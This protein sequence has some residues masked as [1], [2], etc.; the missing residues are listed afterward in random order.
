MSLQ[1]KF[2]PREWN[3]IAMAQRGMDVKDIARESGIRS[4]HVAAT[5]GRIYRKLGIQTRIKQLG[6]WQFAFQENPPPP[7]VIEKP[8]T[9]V[10]RNTAKA[11]NSKELIVKLRHRDGDG[12]FFC[13]NPIDFSLAGKWRENGPTMHIMKGGFPK[14][15]VPDEKRK[16]A[17]RACNPMV[18]WKDR[19]EAKLES[20]RRYNDKR[21]ERRVLAMP[22]GEIVS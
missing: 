6:V 12:C 2:S 7:V 3:F 11:I 16:L 1:P 19:S 8:V 22:S 21:K 14:G 17:H 15:P 20:H 9:N 4:N 13:G 10:K 18:K 5:L